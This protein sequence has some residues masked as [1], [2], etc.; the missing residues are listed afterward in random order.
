MHRILLFYNILVPYG[1]AYIWRFA[2]NTAFAIWKF[3]AFYSVTCD[4]KVAWHI[5]LVTQAVARA[6]KLQRYRGNNV[7]YSS[8]TRIL[9]AGKACM[10]GKSMYIIK[11]SYHATCRS[12]ADLLLHLRQIYVCYNN[13]LIMATYVSYEICYS[14]HFESSFG[15]LV[16]LSNQIP[17]LILCL[18]F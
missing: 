8:H 16:L 18:I 15:V 17:S 9:T 6:L 1:R 4:N 7:E 10:T 2:K 3:E 14:E 13:I 12:L 5:K 11:N